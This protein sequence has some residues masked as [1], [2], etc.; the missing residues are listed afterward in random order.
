MKLQTKNF[1]EIDVK[2]SE[3]I[4]FKNGIPGFLDKK[5][6]TLITNFENESFCW[7]Q[8]IDDTDLTFVLLDMGK[9]M[10]EYDPK[11]NANEIAELGEVKNNLLIYNVVVIPDS[12]ENMT[13]NL[14]APIVINKDTL[15]G[16]QVIVNN[17][18]YPI[19]H[20]IFKN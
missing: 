12:V 15:T 10:P 17:D 11:I 9:I 6:F 4:T 8:S 18:D 1:G 14:K 3:I 13:V 20:Y 7:L 19:R 16:K 2:D 5:K